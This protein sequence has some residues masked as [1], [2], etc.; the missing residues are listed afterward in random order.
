MTFCKKNSTQ[1][2][3]DVLSWHRH[4]NLS[5][6]KNEEKEFL[7]LLWKLT[8]LMRITIIFLDQFC[9]V[10]ALVVVREILNT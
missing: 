1:D 9:L 3:M 2:F 10:V 4:E 6:K 7:N 8:A 5:N